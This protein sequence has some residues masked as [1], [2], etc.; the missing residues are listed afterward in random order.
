LVYIKRIFAMRRI[1]VKIALVFG[2]TLLFA[3]IAISLLGVE[4]TDACFSN[5]SES[6]C[7]A[8]IRTQRLFGVFG[9]AILAF[10]V[11]FPILVTRYGQQL[12]E[13]RKREDPSVQEVAVLQLFVIKDWNKNE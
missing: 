2:V 4:A 9:G 1:H 13:S 12:E 7:P 10:F 5:A 8:L 3:G 11:V 6:A